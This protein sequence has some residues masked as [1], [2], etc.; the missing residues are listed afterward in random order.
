MAGANDGQT[1]KARLL[2]AELREL[3]ENADMTVRDLAAQLDVAPGTVSRYERG[4]RAPK[5]EHV[6]RVL[7]T[8]GVTGDRYDEIIEFAQT[9]T[10]P[11]MIADGSK[12]LHRHLI[13]LSEFDRS[14]E[15][16]LH[17]APLLVPGPMQT[18]AYAAEMMT[19]LPADQRDVRVELRM[20]RTAALTT[21]SQVD[22]VITERALREPLGGE[23]VMAEQ[24]RHLYDLAQIP[25]ITIRALPA[26]KHWTLA[27]N[28][29]FVLYEFPKASPIVHLEHYRGPAFLYDDRDVQAYREEAAT[30]PRVTMSPDDSAD[31]MAG[32]AEDLERS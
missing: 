6:A 19:T 31:L 17:V 32:I 30:L 25:N 18:R 2:G 26:L 13:E 4:E 23:K 11:N 22:V 7:G 16:A 28:G 20:A 12:G 3:R 10:E 24:V 9:A 27:H 14:A 29:A 21:P 1:P 5:S 8:L 15:R